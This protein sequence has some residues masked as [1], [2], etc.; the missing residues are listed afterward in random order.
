MNP[1]MRALQKA[2]GAK[3]P[4]DSQTG[5][6]SIRKSDHRETPSL[7]ALS[8]SSEEPTPPWSL[9]P[10]T[11]SPVQPGARDLS[12]LP[13]PGQ[14]EDQTRGPDVFGS[15]P[16]RDT[17]AEESFP[18]FRRISDNDAEE[19]PHHGPAREISPA[20]TGITACRRYGRM[21]LLG[22]L[23][24]FLSSVL[25]G[26][27]V[28]WKVARYDPP[29]IP[30]EL[31]PLPIPQEY[32][33]MG[34]AGNDPGLGNRAS[35]TEAAVHSR[36]RART[37]AKVPGP[38]ARRV[39]HAAAPRSLGAATEH[40]ARKALADTATPG[41][42][43][44]RPTGPS[45]RQARTGTGSPPSRRISVKSPE[46][47]SRRGDADPRAQS[48]RIKITRVR[49]PDS[50]HAKLQAGFD[51]FEKGD[52]AGADAAYRAVFREQPDN[53]DAL[54]GLAA[55][56]MR[57]RQ[58]E[59]AAGHYLRILRGNPGDPVARAALLGLQDNLDPVVGESRIKRLLEKEPDAPYLHF[60]LGNLYARRSYWTEAERAYF[61]A[62]QA[63]NANAD[64]S[65]NLAV[66]LDHLA[67]RK[68][69]LTYYRRA[70]DLAGEQSQPPGFDPNAVRR[71]IEA[72]ERKP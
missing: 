35:D 43:A 17:S 38:V 23:P 70:L 34:Y 8:P 16:N 39:A 49:V 14:P 5:D 9:A 7:K 10:M 22:A 20:T 36:P 45:E 46:G 24:L 3:W 28:F 15:I 40:R 29:D 65:Y 31:P 53:R 26:A 27:Y 67:K 71:R 48:E 54:L 33:A 55:V 42:P 19:I 66:S 51:A 32:A 12:P 30:G 21:A 25:A 56:A 11:P 59:T 69:A 61:N 18:E 13:G 52:I 2:R 47:A 37:D 50:L 57:Q 63:D 4:V 44:E 64:Y 60:S 6:G 41:R 68:A 1:L 62:Y 72:I 58:W